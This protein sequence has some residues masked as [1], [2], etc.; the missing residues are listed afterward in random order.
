MTNWEKISERSCLQNTLSGAESIRMSQL[1]EGRQLLDSIVA[2]TV[3]AIISWFRAASKD[4]NQH[5]FQKR[6]ERRLTM[7][8]EVIGAVVP[9]LNN[10]AP[11]EA[12]P[13][14]PE[15]LAKARL[16]VQLYG[17]DDEQHLFEELVSARST[18]TSKE[19]EKLS[20]LSCRQFA[21]NCVKKWVTPP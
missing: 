19:L 7:F 15:K 9:L 2:S 13:E 11:F 21:K 5:L 6:V 4:R 1:H 17:Y 16:S 8:D 20:P 10:A 3:I 12:D 14:L 18:P